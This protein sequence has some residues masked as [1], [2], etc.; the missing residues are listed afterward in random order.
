M[1]EVAMPSW[2]ETADSPNSKQWEALAT[3]HREPTETETCERIKGPSG[4]YR[5]G[6]SVETQGQ[7]STQEVD[8]SSL[9][10]QATQSLSQEI[11][12]RSTEETTQLM[13]T[14]SSNQQT[15][16]SSAEIDVGDSDTSL[17]AAE[18]SRQSG[19]RISEQRQ[20]QTLDV[21]ALRDGLDVQRGVSASSAETDSER[22]TR[23][24]QTWMAQD[25]ASIQQ[26]TGS[27]IQVAVEES[28]GRTGVSLTGYTNVWTGGVLSTPVGRSQEVTDGV[29]TEKALLMHA[30]D[31]DNGNGNGKDHASWSMSFAHTEP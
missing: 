31:H 21:T 12:K 17:T 2:M 6:D 1:K 7:A 24:I 9:V 13:T 3:E 30:Y 25:R 14:Q 16:Q 19:G 28:S 5:G 4:E 18:S 27:S 29:R 15:I 20:V 8:Q 22:I 26:M 23:D 10:K 11:L